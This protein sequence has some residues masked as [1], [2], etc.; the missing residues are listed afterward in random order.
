[1]NGRDCFLHWWEHVGSLY[2]HLLSPYV[3]WA[4][5]D[6]VAFIIYLFLCLLSL[7]T[8]ICEVCPRGKCV[9]GVL[10]LNVVIKFDLG[11]SVLDFSLLFLAILQISWIGSGLLNH[12]RCR[13][14]WKCL[15]MLSETKEVST[16]AARQPAACPSLIAGGRLSHALQL[17]NNNK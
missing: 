11:R 3:L 14:P 6:F 13:L 12:L 15:T 4:V 17:K 2:L 9:V 7:I 16:L 5:W 10:D 1:M 8:H